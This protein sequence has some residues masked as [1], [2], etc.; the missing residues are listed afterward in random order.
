MTDLSALNQSH[1]QAARQFVATD[2][3]FA[4]K[5]IM[6]TGAGDGIG[7]ALALGLASKGAS[8]IL[9]G[10]TRQK[11]NEVYDQIEAAGHPQAA[12]VPLNLEL[13]KPHQYNELADMLRTEFGRLDGLVHNAGQLGNITPID[14][15][16]PDT[17]LSV[18]QVN[19]NAAFFL[20]RAMLPLLSAAPTA[21][22]VFTT[23][24]VGR[25]GR[26]FWGAYAVSKFAVEGLTQ[27]LADELDNMTRIRVNA[28]NPGACHTEMR[29]DAYPA[30]DR[31]LLAR[32]ADI[33]PAW[34]YLLADDCTA[35]GLSLDAQ[36]PK[37]P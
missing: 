6:V 8:V 25:K 34:Y 35:N 22:L 32:P 30:E 10:R 15:Y 37:K 23:S 2:K 7:R 5:V 13:A 29:K 36:V 19:V 21:S 9:L 3:L 12:V 16:P 17:W 4:G 28:I 26:A 33:L 24:S 18:M 27:V 20:T 31:S 11:L 1:S 14:Q